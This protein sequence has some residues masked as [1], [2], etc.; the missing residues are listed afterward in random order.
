MK[1]KIIIEIE[2][3]NMNRIVPEEY[4]NNGHECPEDELM[5]DDIEEGIH[6]LFSEMV[7]SMINDDRMNF[8]EEVL[9]N[10][11]SVEG[12]DKLSDYGDIKIS[13][14]EDKD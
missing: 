4:I 5:T 11:L 3:K 8:E 9:S 12:F 1:T 2:T 10:E 13:V 6:K 7:F 14:T